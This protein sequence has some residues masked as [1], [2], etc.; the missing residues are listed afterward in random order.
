MLGIIVCPDCHE[1]IN[2]ELNREWKQVRCPICGRVLERSANM[3][4]KNAENH[5]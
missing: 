4:K 1:R 2:V 5:D 3:E